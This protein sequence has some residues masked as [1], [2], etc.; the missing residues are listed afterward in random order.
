MLAIRIGGIAAAVVEVQHLQIPIF[1]DYPCH[2]VFTVSSAL[3][4][5]GQDC[6]KS[7]YPA[8]IVTNANCLLKI[9]R[10]CCKLRLLGSNSDSTTDVDNICQDRNVRQT[11]LSVQM[12]VD[13]R[14]AVCKPSGR[15]CR[16]G[17]DSLTTNM[18]KIAISL[19]YHHVSQTSPQENPEQ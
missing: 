1:E 11:Q 3:L 6:R 13:G 19:P 15:S 2:F 7:S 16:F 17:P 5:N 18:I 10:Y 14:E 8:D 4:T 12:A 9:V